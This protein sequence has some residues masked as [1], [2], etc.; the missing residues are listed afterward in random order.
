MIRGYEQIKLDNV[1]Q[2]REAVR[3]LGDKVDA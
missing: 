3:E 2:H 1:R